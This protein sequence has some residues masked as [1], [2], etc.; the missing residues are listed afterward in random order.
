MKHWLPPLLAVAGLSLL[1]YLTPSG[2]H[3]ETAPEG[4]HADDTIRRLAPYDIAA[5]SSSAR[6]V[7]DVP[8][9]DVVPG[10]RREVFQALGL[11]DRRV[12]DFQ[13][14]AVHRVVFLRWQ[15]SPSYDVVCM[16][17]GD[18]REPGAAPLDDPERPVSGVRIVS[19]A[20]GWRLI[21]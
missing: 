16:T 13:T 4:L 7:L 12:R 14:S 5:A 20:E 2:R 10:P 9:L 19:R 1:V 3:P 18:D 11:D 6:S 21:W 17:A 8:R 15:V